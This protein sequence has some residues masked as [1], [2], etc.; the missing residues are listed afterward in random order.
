M[1]GAAL[2]MLAAAHAGAPQAKAPAPA[3]APAPPAWPVTEGDATLRDFRFGTGETLPDIRMHYRTL[4]MP[5]R[6]ASGEIDNA[7]MLLHGTGGTGAQFLVPQFSAELFGPGQPLDTARYFI[8]M[9]DNLGHGLSTRPSEG[10][11]MAFPRYD[12]DDMVEAERR[13]LVEGLGVKRL[14]LILGTSMGCMQSFVWGVTHPDF[15]RALMPLACEPV[16]LAGLNRM[17]RQLAIN[18]IK[19]DPEWQSGN[20]MT[21]PQRGLRTAYSLQF[22]AG[23][24]PL[25]LQKSYPTRDAAGDYAET[26]VGRAVAGLD[27]NNL[28]YHLESSRNYNPWPRLESITAP[29]MWINSADDFINPR[30]FGYPQAAVKRMPHARFRQIAESEQT[31][32]H[33]THT[34]AK[35]WKADLIDLLARTQ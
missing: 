30:N 22:V 20:Y 21:Q 23:G 17:W 7:V 19:T 35:F 2:L 12:Y 8:I 31:R 16:E 24:A 9:P 15:S 29:M 4:G 5:H 18:A 10:M 11:R 27:A 14:R 28:I 32:G 33:S 1:L 26:T 34:W 6:D 3:P 25:Y 13:M